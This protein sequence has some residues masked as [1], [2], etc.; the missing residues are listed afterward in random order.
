MVGTK[1]I[2][3]IHKIEFISSGCGKTGKILGKCLSKKGKIYE[4]KK[5][6]RKAR[7]IFADLFLL[8]VNYFPILFLKLKK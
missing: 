6:C 8:G 3:V 2:S 7:V 4:K 5:K 1:W